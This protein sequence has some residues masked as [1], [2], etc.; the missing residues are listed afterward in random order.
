M[1]LIFIVKVYSKFSLDVF[2]A[3]KKKRK[4][5]NKWAWGNK[6]AQG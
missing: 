5:G 4:H 6:Y 2:G 3:V 1:M